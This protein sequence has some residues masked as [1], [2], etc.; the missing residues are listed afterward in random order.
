MMKRLCGLTL[1]GLL[2]MATPACAQ[3]TEIEALRKEIA[4]LREDLASLRSS[5]GRAR[6]I[7]DLSTG[8]Q[9]G[10]HPSSHR[11]RLA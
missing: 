8:H 9:R 6:P 3:S 11:R 2:V 1:L 4:D 7:I 5:L 10:R